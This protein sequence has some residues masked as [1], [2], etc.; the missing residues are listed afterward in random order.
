MI[1]VQIKEVQ[2]NITL[3]DDAVGVVVMQPFVELGGEEPFRWRNDK[4]TKQIERIIR[5]LEIAKQ[6]D[7]GCEKTYFT[8]FPEYSIPGL[9][10]V[11]KIQEILE[12]NSWDSGTI[13]MGGVDGLAKDDYSTLCNKDNTEVIPQNRSDNILETQW[14]NCCITWVKDLNG[15]FKKWVQPKLVPSWLE[16]NIICNDMFCGNLVY[17]FRCKFKNGVDCRFLSLICFDWIG[18]INSRKGIW[19]VLHKIN[20]NW[21]LSGKQ[22]INFIFVLQN[23]DEPNHR[24][25]LENTR[26][27]F[28]DRT[29]FPFAVRDNCVVI[30]ANTA[31]GLL[32]GEYE[33]YGY[34]SLV[35]SPNS[36]YDTKSCPP[37]FSI[38]TKKFRNSDNLGR[39]KYALFREMGACIHSFEFC[40]PSFINLGLPGRTLLIRRAIVHS[41]DQ[42]ISDP[43][44][45]GSPVPASIKWINDQLDGITSILHYQTNSS[46]RGDIEW[47]HEDICKTIRVCPDT[48]LSKCIEWGVYGYDKW[49]DLGSRKIPDVD[50]WNEKE[51]LGLSTVIYSLSVINACKSL[52]L[53]NPKSHAVIKSGANIIDVIVVYGGETSEKCFNYGTQFLT[54][55]QRFGI[56]I[57][58]DIHECL[59]NKRDKLI[60]ETEGE[61]NERGPIITDPAS[62][63][64]HCG[65]SNL[66]NACFDSISLT[67]LSDKITK[68]IGV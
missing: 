59:V 25:F 17:I 7:H 13:I 60:F 50:N 10:G 52:E 23:N 38:N 42:G 27:Y 57:T 29:S 40:S 19:A 44:V 43:R 45:P 30:F 4:K 51:E 46:L 36:P 14:V 55:G 8:I 5:T 9:E 15:S 32:P 33:R 39:C 34:S 21:R 58:R 1:M 67:D 2:L 66:K 31:G 64:I 28:E 54:D 37:T 26:N 49:L 16:R 22:D 65:Y 47:S 48:F 56:V 41:I 20:E 18:E 11:E 3:P 53:F 61:I 24:V 12:S 6:A 63:I 62:R 35:C 68:I